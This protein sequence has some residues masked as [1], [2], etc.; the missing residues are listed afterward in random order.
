MSAYATTEVYTN[1]EEIQAKGAYEL[2]RTSGY[3]SMSEAIH[4]VEDGNITDMPMLTR[5]DV[6][7]VYDMYGIPLEFIRG[8]MTKKKVSRAIVDESLML[9]EKK[10]VLYSDIM[11]INSNKFLI[12]VRK[13]LQLVMQCKIE[14]ESQ[15][16]LGFALQGQLNLLRSRSFVPTVVHMDPQSAFC[17]LT[18]SSPEVVIDVGGAGDYVAKVD[19][20]IRRIKEISRKVKA[21]LNWKL[22]PTMV[23]DLVAYAVSW[24]NIRRTM[25]INQNVCPCV[26]FTGM[27]VSYKKELELAFGDYVE[28]YDGTDNTSKSRSIP[29]SALFPCCNS[30]GSWEFMSLKSKT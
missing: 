26:L 5:E 7:Q 19:A 21:G 8:K 6:W 20:K 27:R 22:P 2:L 25:A 3:T 12:T 29:C 1:A 4:L 15:S 14:R 18:G 23:K 30:T 17:A 11:H 28:V 10:R 16:K 9:D 13:P 24:I